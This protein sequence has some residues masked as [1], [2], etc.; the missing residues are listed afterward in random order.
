MRRAILVVLVLLAPLAMGA[1][2]LRQDVTTNLGVQTA[3]AQLTGGDIGS[4]SIGASGTS[5]TVTLNSL[6]LLTA[7]DILRLDST[8]SAWSVK[9]QLV[10]QSGW[11]A[12]ESI[13]ISLA[14][15]L[16]TESQIVI[17]LG[18]VTKTVGN[19]VDLPVGS[20]DT[21]VRVIGVGTGSI[22]FDLVLQPDSQPGPTLRYSVTL[23]V[24]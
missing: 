1:V 21:E 16:L 4:T 3:F 7:N 13:T 12:T 11:G 2:S 14:D 8:N 23:T 19:L 5:A 15:G 9:A 20:T 10:S 6:P 17:S 24:G 22:T 18:S